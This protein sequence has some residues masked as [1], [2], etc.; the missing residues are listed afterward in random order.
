MSR[1]QAA[2]QV[3][4]RGE[5]VVRTEGGGFQALLQHLSSNLDRAEVEQHGGQAAAVRR[6][7]PAVA[8]IVAASAT[9]RGC[10]DD[11]TT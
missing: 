9:T 11:L 7:G 10:D 3:R 5:A 6:A 4:D 8:W 2:M 1:Q